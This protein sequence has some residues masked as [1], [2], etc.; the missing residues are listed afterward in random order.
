MNGLAKIRNFKRKPKV[1]HHFLMLKATMNFNNC[2]VWAIDT[3]K[4]QQAHVME[5][6]LLALLKIKLW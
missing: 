3:G 6:G 1:C 4:R 2:R 5:T